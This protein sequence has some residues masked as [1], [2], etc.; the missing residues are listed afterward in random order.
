MTRNFRK[1]SILSLIVLLLLVLGYYRDF[2]F[3]E[4]NA[5]I[6]SKE[7]NASY[8]AAPSIQFMQD[9]ATS[10]LIKLKWTLTLLFSLVY[11]GIALF[12]I[13]LIFRNP[14][15]NR[16]TIITYLVV[17]FISGIFMLIGY[18]FTGLSDKMY[19]FSRYLMGMA[20]SPIILMILIPA[21][22]LSLQERSNIPN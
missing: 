8:T 11:L 15:F 14:K 7:L 3:K 10:F 19:E 4:I 16:I 6:Q 20:Q 1:F 12:T 13:H 22:K 21:F 17:G 2:I 9:Y 5:I 18:V